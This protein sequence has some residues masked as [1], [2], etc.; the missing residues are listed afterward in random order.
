[1][2]ARR[3]AS[4]AAPLGY[5]KPLCSL[6]QRSRAERTETVQTPPAI[7]GRNSASAY[8]STRHEAKDAA[9]TAFQNALVYLLTGRT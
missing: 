8:A 7:I 2:A 5:D 1:M 4:T 6:A 3:V 9:V